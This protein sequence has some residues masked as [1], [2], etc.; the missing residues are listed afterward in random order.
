MYFWI[1]VVAPSSHSQSSQHTAVC[2][3]HV[4]LMWMR[5]SDCGYTHTCDGDGEE[6]LSQSLKP[7]ARAAWRMH[8]LASINF[9]PDNTRVIHT[10]YDCLCHLT[11]W[12]RADPTL[13]SQVKRLTRA[14]SHHPTEIPCVTPFPFHPFS[15]FPFSNSVLGVI[16]A[17]GA[18]GQELSPQDERPSVLRRNASCFFFLRSGKAAGDK[19]LLLVAAS[20]NFIIPT[21]HTLHPCSSVWYQ[22]L[23]YFDFFLCAE[24]MSGYSYGT[25]FT[26]R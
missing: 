3:S 20:S 10:V 5:A 7:P 6:G 21:Q 18:L 11:I 1:Y 2:T 4:S 25:Q 13:F 14:F 24:W 15:S 8:K 19:L 23:W 9:Y 22:T 12:H 16:M 17:G 26:V